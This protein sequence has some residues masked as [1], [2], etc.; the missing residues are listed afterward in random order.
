MA[1]P[2]GPESRPRRPVPAALTELV[3]AVDRSLGPA[4]FW[5]FG[6]RARGDAGPDS[7]WDILAVLPDEVSPELL[8]PLAAWEV[9]YSQN[10]PVTLLTTTRAELRS[11]WDLPNT[12]GYD[13]AREG[14]RL[15]VD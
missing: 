6:S 2:G 4:E 7:D 3:A 8:D 13:L 11:I 14:V 12:I 15:V 9:R 5:L 1:D 10:T